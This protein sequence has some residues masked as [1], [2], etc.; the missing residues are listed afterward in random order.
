VT[1]TTT[2]PACA[3]PS[4]L[5]AMTRNTTSTLFFRRDG[6]M[7]KASHAQC[8]ADADRVATALRTRG[9]LPGDRVA[10]HGDTS[11]DWV[12]AD[13]ACLLAGALS[14][15][16]YASAPVAR[17]LAAAVESGCRVALTDRPDAATALA[18]AGLDVLF[19]GGPGSGPPGV[20]AIGDLLDGPDSVTSPPVP[21]PRRRGAFTV[22]STSGTL[23]EP[24]LFVV[25]SAPLLSTMDRFAEIYGLDGRDRLVLYLP[26]SHL[27]QRM[28]LYWGLGAGMDFV[29]SDPVHLTADSA[30]LAPTL[31]VAVPRVLEHLRWRVTQSLGLAARDSA[32]ARARAYRAAFGPAIRAIFV[33][34]APTDPAL[35]EELL[36]AGLA[37]YEVYGTTELGM[38]GLNTPRATRPGTVGRAIP[39]GDVRLHPETSEIEVCT[40]TPFRY[41]SLADGRVERHAWTPGAYQPTGDVGELDGDGFLTVRGRLQD[42]LALSSGEKV[43]VRPIEDA[44]AARTGAAL[45]QL[46]HV[47]PAHP[48]A[49]LFFEPGSAPARGTVRDHLVALNATLHPWERIRAFAVVDRLPSIEEGCLTETTKP[50]RHVIDALFGRAADWQPVRRAPGD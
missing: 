15:A 33:G 12:L 46:T 49:L 24:R 11:Y 36:D 7:A 26:L 42:F 48:G 1:T 22:V 47:D 30:E 45:C 50:R 28:M 21:A 41:G 25:H 23:S 19:L 38:I 9:V 43:F 3:L 20:A 18:A 16:L 5:D 32:V 17:V 27:P 6:A 39:W 8:R 40:P 29:L 2:E 14:V 10:V 34:S 4:V 37:V 13:L 44:A 35:L 31:H